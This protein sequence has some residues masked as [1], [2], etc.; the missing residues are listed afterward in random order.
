[1]EQHSPMTVHKLSGHPGSVSDPQA[2]PTISTCIS[3]S[4]EDQQ[5]HHGGLYQ[6][7]GRATFTPVTH[8]G[9]QADAM[10]QQMF[11]LSE[12]DTLAQNQTL[13]IKEQI[14]YPEVL[15]YSAT[16]LCIQSL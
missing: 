3:C 8:T 1:M 16:G 5:K 14:C 13:R 10:K 2:L 9:M 6:S 7:S 4:C 11:P 15:H 12:S